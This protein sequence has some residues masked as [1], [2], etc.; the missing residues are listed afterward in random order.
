MG[1]EVISNRQG[2]CALTLFL[3]GSTLI[4]GAAGEAKRDVWI[5]IVAAAIGG[6]LI[7]LVYARLLFIFPGK[8]LIEILEI[9][10]GKVIGKAIGLLFIWYAFHLGTLVL[11]NLGEFIDN[12]ALPETPMIVSM[13]I[14]SFLSAWVAKEGVEVLGR[15]SEIFIVVLFTIIFTIQ[16]LITPQLHFRNIEPVL[17]SGFGIVAQGALSAFTF[18]FAESVLFLMILSNLQKKESPYKAYR[19]GIIIG[20]SMILI[21]SMR[22]I[23][24]LGADIAELLYFPSYIAV[25]RINVANFLQRLEIAVSIVFVVCV[26]VKLSICL[27]ASAK[28]VARIFNLADYRITV[29]PIVILMINVSYILYENAMEM[30]EWAFKVYPYYALPFQVVLPIIILIAAEIK[31]RRARAK[32]HSC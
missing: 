7:S 4:L 15:L 1:K 23:L 24:V 25:T 19:W 12:V 6:I 22:N 16:I 28:G 20:G 9:V 27:L 8:D 26:W 11:R 13:V 30:V 2:I 10:F 14:I 18:P 29:F 17:A 32:N 31:T 21:I 5:A 3:M